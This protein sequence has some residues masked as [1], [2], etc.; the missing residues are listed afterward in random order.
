M[1]LLPG[2]ILVRDLKDERITYSFVI[3]FQN[4]AVTNFRN[5]EVVYNL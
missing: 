1:K 2:Q 4:N 3:G 5:T